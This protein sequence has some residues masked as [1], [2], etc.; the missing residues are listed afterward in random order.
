MTDPRPFYHRF[1]WAYD[2]LLDEPIDARVAGIVSLLGKRGVRPGAAVL[3]AGCGSGRYASALAAQG[4]RVLGVDRSAELVKVAQERGRAASGNITFSVGD[5]TR[6]EWPTQ[7]GAIL[8]RG[9]LND[10]LADDDREQISRRFADLVAPGGALLLDVRDWQRTTLRYRI[11]STTGRTI[12]LTDSGRLIFESETALD[13]S[14]QQMIVSEIFE[15]HAA[16][17][18]AVERH[19][20]EFRMRCWSG[21]ELYARFEP[22]F[23]NLAI[24]PD[25]VEPAAWTDRLVLVGTRRRTL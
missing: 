22:W 7:F 21:E 4:F 10:L 18:T 19:A 12:D 2:L 3:D 25:Y 6:F 13:A 20:T 1:A 8:C 15:L 5:L 17:T 9:A 23:E 24:L 14:I 11:R 16:G